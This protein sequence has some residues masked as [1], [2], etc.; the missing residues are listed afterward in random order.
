LTDGAL[1]TGIGLL[2]WF[3][4]LQSLLAVILPLPS[5]IALLGILQLMV[6]LACGY[7]AFAE[8]EKLVEDQHPLTDITFPGDIRQRPNIT[9]DLSSLRRKIEQRMAALLTM[10]KRVSQ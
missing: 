5:L 9:L 6:A 2:F 7:L 3:I 8:N 1:F 4:P 10:L